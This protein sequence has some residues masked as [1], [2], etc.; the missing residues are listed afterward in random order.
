MLATA[1]LLGITYPQSIKWLGH[2]LTADYKSAW[3]PSGGKANP[4]LR[5]L[6]RSSCDL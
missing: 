4:A 1:W 6:K 5:K 2:F 3:T